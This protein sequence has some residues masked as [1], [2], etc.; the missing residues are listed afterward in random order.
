L[1]KKVFNRALNQAIS[2]AGPRYTP[3]IHDGFPSLEIQEM[4]DATNGL[5]RNESFWSKFNSYIT[6]IEE[7]IKTNYFL[8][9]GRERFHDIQQLSKTCF[10]LAQKLRKLLIKESNKRIRIYKKIDLVSIQTMIL[11]LRKTLDSA[12]SIAYEFRFGKL[13]NR[14]SGDDRMYADTL[15]GSIREL[16]SLADN[17]T[18]FFRGDGAN[19]ANNPF[20]LLLGHAG[21]GKT[22]FLCDF[23]K[24]NIQKNQE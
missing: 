17:A 19:L 18:D 13:S 5:L 8:G 3:G 15:Y 14:L 6:K 24:S 1:N 12:H 11:E 16:E 10:R 23:A 9:S 21:Y 2:Q 20:C 7:S 22:H 4:I